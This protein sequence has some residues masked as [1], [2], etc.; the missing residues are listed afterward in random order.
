MKGVSHF[1]FL[2][3]SL[4][5]SQFS[6]YMPMKSIIPIPI[7]FNPIQCKCNNSQGLSGGK[8]NSLPLL[9][10][11]RLLQMLHEDLSI[12][13]DITASQLRFLAFAAR[14][15]GSPFLHPIVSHNFSP[16]LILPHFLIKTSNSI[17]S[18]PIQSHSSGFY[19]FMTNPIPYVDSQSIQSN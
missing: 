13:S 10:E 15:V 2:F 5:S 9:I 11:W 12:S 14:R 17:Q 6:F 1:L 16:L 18:N 7:Q 3:C 19:I 8:A 4:T